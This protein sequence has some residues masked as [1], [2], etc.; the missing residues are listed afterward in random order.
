MDDNTINLNHKEGNLNVFGTFSHS[1]PSRVSDISLD[2]IVNN[3]NNG[4]TYFDQQTH[5]QSDSHNNV[6]RLGAGYE[7]SHENTVG[8]SVSGYDNSS[9][10][11][12]NNNTKIQS[13]P[14]GIPDSLVNTKSD[15]RNTNKN[16]AINI[17]DKLK[18]DTNGQE[19]SADLDYVKYNNNTFT[20]YT[21]DFFF[22]DGDTQ[23]PSKF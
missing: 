11:N 15:Q 21:N 19:L 5:R 8:F 2:R 9:N 22:A 7:T 17:N 16:L 12:N 14:A 10:V 4:L 20:Q 23:N 3:N 6:Y 13:T 1:D 18:L